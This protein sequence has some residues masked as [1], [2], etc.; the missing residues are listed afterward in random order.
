MTESDS[1]T[2]RSE[3]FPVWDDEFLD[4]VAHRLRYHYDVERDYLVDGERFELYGKLDVRYERHAIHPSLTFGHHEAHEHLFVTH[5]DRP[6]VADLER[7]TNLGERLAEEWIEAD[8]DHYSTDFTFAVVAAELS[9]AVREH[10]DG[11]RNRTLLK[12]GYNGHYEIN[13]LVVVPE[14]EESVASQEADAEQAFRVWEPVVKEEPGRLGRLLN[15][16][17]R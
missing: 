13:L 17:S 9:E 1:P 4:A 5:V 15:W 3:E 11:Y 16:L 6:A 8:E 7:L 2:D 14:H 10:V 12:Y